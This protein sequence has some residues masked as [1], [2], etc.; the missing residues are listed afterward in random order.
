MLI[1]MFPMK[2]GKRPAASN[3]Y[4]VLDPSTVN[5][6]ANYP[7]MD[8]DPRFYRTFAFP[9]VRWA[10]NGDPRGEQNHHPYNG[11]DYELWNYVWY[12]KAEDRDNIESGSTYGPDNLMGNVKGMYIRKRTDDFDNNTCLYVFDV[13]NN[14]FKQSAAPYFELRYAEVLLNYAEAAA[15]AGKMSV[16]VEQLKRIRQRVGYTGD[17][18]LQG[19]LTSNQA[20]CLAAVL[21]ERQ[22]ELAYEGKRFDDMRRWMLFDGGVNVPAGASSNFNLTGWN[23]NTCTYLGYE[24][25]N[26]RRRDNMEFRVQSGYKNGLGK[27][28]WADDLSHDPIGNVTRPAGVDYRQDLEP[29]LATLKTFYQ[30]Y[31]ERNK[32]KGDSYDSD[33]TELFVDFKPQYYILGFSQ[34]VHANNSG[35]EQTMGWNDTQHGGAGKFD[36]LALPVE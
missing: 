15:G 19:S 31:L 33:H 16:A 14:G 10:F 9:G 2:E 3:A 30:T 18:G 1:D 11:R 34:G 5:Y 7:F 32:K 25:L 12:T 8:R 27:D 21:Y 13:T 36:P 29:Q 28:T 4:T 17:C 35:L 23:G 20:A 22:I 6:D 24:P 26:G